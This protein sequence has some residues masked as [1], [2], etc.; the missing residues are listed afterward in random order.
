[1]KNNSQNTNESNSSH[2][3]GLKAF[4]E[5]EKAKKEKLIRE[6]TVIKK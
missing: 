5:I 3:C 4:V 6:K 1:M 2:T